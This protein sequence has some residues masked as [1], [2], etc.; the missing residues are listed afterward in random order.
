MGQNTIDFVSKMG[1]K[2]IV[3]VPKWGKSAQYCRKDGAKRT[4]LQSA[5]LQI[6]R[7]TMY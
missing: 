7:L 6:R 3:Y 4:Y 1:Q 5:N 2:P